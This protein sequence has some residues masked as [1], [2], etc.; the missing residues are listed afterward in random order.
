MEWQWAHRLAPL[1][2]TFLLDIMKK[3]YFLKYTNLPYISDMLIVDDTFVIFQNEKESEEFLIRLNGLHS[4]P[5]FTF[6]KNNNSLQF[7]EVHISIIQ[8]IYFYSLQY[9]NQQN[10]LQTR[11]ISIITGDNETTIR[12][13]KVSCHH[14]QSTW[15][16]LTE[17]WAKSKLKVN[18]Q[19][20][21][22]SSTKLTFAANPRSLASIYAGNPLRP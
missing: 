9:L 6:K 15:K 3:S 21:R 7:L 18:T 19:D 10:Y 16:I 1:R 17:T 11:K 8:S 4:S 13:F 14:G 5:Q 12:S 2:S 22:R 20:T